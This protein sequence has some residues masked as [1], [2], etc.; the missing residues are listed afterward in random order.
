ME[1]TGQA[2]GFV[3][4]AEHGIIL[5]N[6]HVVT[7]GPVGGRGGVPDHEVVT[8]RQLYHDPVHDFGLYQYDPAAL[9]YIHPVSSSSRRTMPGGHHIR[10]IGNDAGEQLSI[11][12]GTLARIDRDARLRR[13]CYNDF[14]PFYFQA[15]SGSTGGSS[16]IAGDQY[17]R[18]G[19]R[20]QRRRAHDAAS[21]YFLPL[22]RV[23]RALALVEAGSPSVVAPSRR[24]SSISITTN[25]DV[26]ACRRIPRR[27]CAS[28]SRM[29]P[30]SWWWTRCS[31][32]DPQTSGCSP[33]DVL[34]RVDGKTISTF[35]PLD[36]IMDS[37]SARP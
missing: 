7:P 24:C 14:K 26:W 17:R 20:P 19:D 10:I 12:S 3:V 16:R 13:R 5:T 27:T 23:V 6:R 15:V 34:L 8:L 11:L 32:T 30:D 31:R 37:R 35:V 9:K 4:D 28:S 33:G 36:E 2:T 29:P 21:S 1:L 18:R 25:S 22:D